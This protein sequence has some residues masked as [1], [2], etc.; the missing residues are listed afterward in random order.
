VSG[1]T[2]FLCH[3]V[4]PRDYD[5]TE[6]SSW[7]ARYCLFGGRYVSFSRQTGSTG[8]CGGLVYNSACLLRGVVLYVQGFAVGGVFFCNR[9][10]HL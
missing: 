9:Y 1:G 7:G 2:L 5:R 3:W 8:Y 10:L 6:G 4:G